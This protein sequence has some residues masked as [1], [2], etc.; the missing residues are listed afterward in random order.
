M[1]RCSDNQSPVVVFFDALRGVV[2]EKVI[3]DPKTEAGIDRGSDHTSNI[4]VNAFSK[5]RNDELNAGVN[6]ANALEVS[7]PND[8]WITPY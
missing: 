1:R 7:I 6:P 5:F 2:D 4:N 3:F 8:K